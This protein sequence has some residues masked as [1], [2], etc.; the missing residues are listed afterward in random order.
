MSTNL[1]AGTIAALIECFS[2]VSDPR[3]E[4]CRRHKLIEIIVIALCT[5]ITGGQGPTEMEAFGEAKFEWLKRFLELPHGIPSHDTFGRVLS[6]IDPKQFAQCL[7]KWV[8]SNVELGVGEVIPIDGKT[9]RRSHDRASEQGAI[10]IV[11]AWAASQ[12]LTL[13]QIKVAEGTNEIT[14]VPQMLD[15]LNVEGC[16]VTVDAAHC[17]KATVAKIRQQKANYVV[18]LKK[19]QKHLYEGVEEYLTSVREDRT[20]GFAI[21]T[22]QTIDKEHG[23]IETRKYWQA[24]A[25]D[26][27]PEKELWQDLSSVG[28]VEATR[29][30]NGK[31]TTELRYYLSSLPVEAKTFGTAVRTH[32]GIENSCHW[33]LDVVLREDDCRIRIGNAAENMSTL[34]RLAMNLLRREKSDKRGVNVKRLKAALD[35]KYLLK[36]LRS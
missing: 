2:D 35:E 17:Q 16:T 26:F 12:R 34:R 4:R 3:I 5:V 8:S 27:L 9:L 19:N 22:H 15:L 14:T 30:I 21:S 23:R 7:L 28:L 13:G 24:S 36:V 11:S 1:P 6:L 25:P 29:E 18:A 31:A 10:E 32:W 33:V 20:V